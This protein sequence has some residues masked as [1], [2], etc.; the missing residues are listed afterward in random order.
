MV[1]EVVADASEEWRAVVGYEGLYEV[2]SLG[3][4]KGIKLSP[5]FPEARILKPST[6]PGWVS[7]GLAVRLAFAENE[8]DPSIGGG[9]L[10]REKTC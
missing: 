2:S 1:D 10:S 3:R 4:V 6:Q 8:N 9:S 7:Y 5:E